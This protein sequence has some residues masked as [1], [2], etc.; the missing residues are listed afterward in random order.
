MGV[1]HTLERYLLPDSTP[2]AAFQA[3]RD[4]ASQVCT[5]RCKCT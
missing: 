3:L 1:L 4:L 5:I 2:E